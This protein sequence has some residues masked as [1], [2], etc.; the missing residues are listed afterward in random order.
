MEEDLSLLR[1][2]RKKRLSLMYD[3]H[4]SLLRKETLAGLG[5]H[6][7][8]GVSHSRPLVVRRPKMAYEA[9]LRRPG[10]TGTKLYPPSG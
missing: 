9:Y 4:Q 6:G 3:H 1:R 2:L 10:G 5:P 7:L 8:A